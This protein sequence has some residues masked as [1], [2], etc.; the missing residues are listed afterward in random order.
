M[1]AAST[2]GPSFARNSVPIR[3]R[4]SRVKVFSGMPRDWASSLIWSLK[5]IEASRQPRAAASPASAQA[6]SPLPTEG[7][8]VRPM[9]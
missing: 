6:T 4:I 8:P 5:E 9:M 1:R 3:E 2:P 7:R